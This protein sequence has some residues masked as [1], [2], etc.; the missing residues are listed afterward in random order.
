MPG[1]GGGGAG[2]QQ[3][4]IRGGS[5]PRS[6]PLP[7]YIPFLIEKVPASLASHLRRLVTQSLLPNERGKLTLQWSPGK[8][9]IYSRKRSTTVPRKIRGN[10][11]TNL[12]GQRNLAFQFRDGISFPA[13]LKR[14]YRH[15]FGIYKL[16]TRFVYQPPVL[17]SNHNDNYRLTAIRVTHYQKYALHYCLCC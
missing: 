11:L 16:G 14:R 10:W 3:S 9:R 5:A 12:R 4:F 6:K 15:G 8:V 7:F 2:T 1:G 17:I 13:Y